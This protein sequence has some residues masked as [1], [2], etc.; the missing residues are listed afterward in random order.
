M[1]EQCLS[2]VHFRG[3]FK[4]SKPSCDAFPLNIPIDIWEGDFD[5]NNPVDGDRGIR[6][7]PTI[8]GD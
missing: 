1:L 6:F 5:H 4:K 2:C 3:S 8:E 7:E